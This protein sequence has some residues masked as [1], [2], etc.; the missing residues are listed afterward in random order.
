LDPEFLSSLNLQDPQALQSIAS[1]V[2][3]LIA[4]DPSQLEGLL[5]EI[6]ETNP[7]ILDFI[8]EREAEFKAL[9]ESPINEADARVL[10]G[11]MGNRQGE[12]EGDDDGEQVEIDPQ[13]ESNLSPADK[14]S[15]ERLKTLGFSHADALQ[16]YLACDKNETLAA[17]FLLEN[18][19]KE[20]DD[21]NIDCK[22][23]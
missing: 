9:L 2:K 15:I 6:E 10:A 12:G 21:M 5:S 23:Y 7:E 4:E 18:K 20:G 19:F 13:I 17:N 22:I 3:I 8:R 11:M 16:A 1:V 14:E